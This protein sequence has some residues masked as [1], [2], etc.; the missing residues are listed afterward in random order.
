MQKS[1]ALLFGALIITTVAVAQDKIKGNGNVTT[2]NISTSDYDKVIVSG[3]Y[4]VDLVEGTE[5]KITIKGEENLLEFVAI[6]VKDNILRIGTEKGKRISPGMGKTITV[7]VPFQSLG[8]VSLAGSGDINSKATIKASKFT[9]SLS[10]SGDVKL[11]VD[12]KDVSSKVTGSGDLTIKGKAD[13]LNCEVT[14]SGDL[15][16]FGLQ[17]ANVDSS[18]TG[19]GNCKVYCTDFLMARVTGSGDINYKGDPKK[20]DTKVHGSGSISKV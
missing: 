20:K 12:A 11:T 18:V 14:G 17:S 13:N 4:D 5:G 1:I 9:T 15:D 8:E 16:A 19:S 2:K 3:F 7:T 10:G 6:E